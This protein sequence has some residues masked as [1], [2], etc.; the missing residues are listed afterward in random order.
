MTGLPKCALFVVCL[1]MSS[2]T[3]PPPGTCLVPAVAMV[4]LVPMVMLQSQVGGEKALGACGD[5]WSSGY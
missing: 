1:L 5:P 4:M 2:G 3:F